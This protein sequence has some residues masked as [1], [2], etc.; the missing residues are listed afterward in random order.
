MTRRERILTVLEGGTPDRPPIAFDARPGA[1][2]GV[3]S[4]YGAC[5][6]PDLYRAA[7]IDGFTVWGW[8]AIM[9]KYMGP[10]RTAADEIA[11]DF[12]GCQSQR[13]YGLAACDTVEELDRHHWP[14]V[15]D[16]DFSHVHARAM[17]IKAQDMPVA[18]GHMGLGYQMHCMLRGDEKALM[19]VLDDTW[20]MRYA[21]RL[22]QFTL[23]YV[24]AL[25]SAGRGEIDVVRADDDMGTMDRLMV[26][27][28]M[29]RRF[30]KPAW[31]AAFEV[32]HRHG[33]KVWLH[34]CGHVWPLLE[35][36][37]EIGVDCWNPFPEYVKDNEHARLKE[38]R[39]T[40]GG[41]VRLALDGGVNHLTLIR[42]CP[43][44]VA[45]QTNRVLD[46]FAQ[47]GGL[48]IG[49][50]QVFTEDMP[51]ENIVAFLETARNYR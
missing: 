19:D 51:T 24:D 20:M 26:S 30:Y 11:L 40:S 12:W 5:D 17:E 25:L 6:I 29:W 38:F 4:Y 2:D 10:E 8:A 31:K 49:P 35:D 32:V 48:L 46:M 44:E 9:G 33:A 14:D 22:T 37:I 28:S 3:F 39:K 41:G 13:H 50:S 27:P 43:Q 34:S 45:D 1:L 42:G 47:D 18:A 15:K 21:E 36:L 23:E 16:F 7:D